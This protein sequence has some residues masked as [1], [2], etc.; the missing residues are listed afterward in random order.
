MLKPIAIAVSLAIALPASAASKR[1]MN[2]VCDAGLSDLGA[3]ICRG[4]Q[5][6]IEKRVAELKESGCH[7]RRADVEYLVRLGHKAEMERA[8]S[9]KRPADLTIGQEETFESDFSVVFPV[10]QTKTG[11]SGENEKR[12]PVAP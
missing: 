12:P 7:A 8:G 3:V 11:R 4:D 5:G 10:P 9:C 6:A 2:E 1:F